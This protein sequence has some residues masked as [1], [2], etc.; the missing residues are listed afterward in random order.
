M[1]NKDVGNRIF[2]FCGGGDTAIMRGGHSYYE[3]GHSYYEGGH[4]YW[5][6][7]SPPLGKTLDPSAPLRNIF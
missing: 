1:I 4:I 6:S 7:P 2:R 5:G 3:G